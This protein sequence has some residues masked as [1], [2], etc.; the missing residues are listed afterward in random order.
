LPTLV[1][2]NL[3]L[4]SPENKDSGRFRE[5]TRE[6]QNIRGSGASLPVGARSKAPVV[7]PGDKCPQNLKHMLCLSALRK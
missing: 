1:V 5:L 7:A 6:M 4:I 2:Q 3:W